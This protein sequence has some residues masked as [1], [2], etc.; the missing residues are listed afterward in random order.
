[1]RPETAASLFDMKRAAERVAEATSGRTF[2]EFQSDWFFQSA[3][4]RQFEILGEALVRVRDLE[5]PV[6][7]RIPDAPKMIGLR[8]ILIHGY[9]AVNPRVLWVIVE[10]RLPELLEVLKGLLEDASRQGL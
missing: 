7:D 9:D 3:V 6:F 5:T 1:M 2:D 10:Q 4:E 8:N